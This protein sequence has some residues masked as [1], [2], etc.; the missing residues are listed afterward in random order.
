MKVA[1]INN[2]FL[3]KHLSQVNIEDRGF[4]FSDSVY[5]VIETYNG[6]LIDKLLHLKRLN[7]SLSQLKINFVLTESKLDAIFSQLSTL[8]YTNNLPFYIQI[9][10]GVSPRNHIFSA[11]KPNVIMYFLNSRKPNISVYENG[12]NAILTNETRWQRRDIK[13][14]SLLANII[15]KQQAKESNAFEAIFIENGFITEGSSTNV[16]IVNDKDEILTH[17]KTNEILWGI[18]REKIIDIAKAQ[19]IK[20]I[21]E[22]FT[23]KQ[24]FEAKE[25]FITSTTAYAIAIVKINEKQIGNGKV[26]NVAK[27][28]YSLYKD[29]V[30]S[31]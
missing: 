28:L 11:T 25:V 16:F 14:T 22:K 21:E 12:V 24:L 6:K 4:Q 13:S 17:P 26:G 2:K 23:Q 29:Y 15:A 8:N 30:Q 1:F 19:S 9:S 20:V 10:R 31:H 7:R 27:T 18:T 3:P 5:E